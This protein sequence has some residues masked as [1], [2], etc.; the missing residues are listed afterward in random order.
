MDD[1]SI[2]PAA[3]RE[4]IS[5]LKQLPGI[6]SRTAERLALSILAWPPERLEAF[7][8]LVGGLQSRI[9]SCVCCGNWADAELCAICRNPGRRRDLICVVERVSQIPVIERS[10]S[11]NG[12]YHVLGGRLMPLEGK[13]PDDLRLRELEG[14]VAA[15][16]VQE[17]I[18]ATSPDVEGEA[19]ASYVVGELKSY[20]VSCSR[21]A[22]G[23]PVGADMS[24]A[25]SA[26]MAMAINSRRPMR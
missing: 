22:S 19:T 12:L 17:V 15:G 10:G 14:R 20:G 9:R 16:G 23:I 18:L 25:D 1:I 11:F 6:G 4:L 2:Y 8:G 26:T 3:L 13:G 21:I 7:G 5:V 24:Y